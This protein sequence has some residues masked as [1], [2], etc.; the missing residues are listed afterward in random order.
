MNPDGLYWTNR[1]PVRYHKARYLKRSGWW[2]CIHDKCRLRART[3]DEFNRLVD[4][5]DDHNRQIAPCPASVETLR[6]IIPT[7]P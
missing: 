5:E 6:K 2:V 7:N 1:R 3:L 4:A